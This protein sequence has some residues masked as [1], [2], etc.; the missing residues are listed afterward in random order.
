M[1]R[2][3]RRVSKDTIKAKADKAVARSAGED[4]V[5]PVA[6][7][8]P[9]IVPAAAI[10]KAATPP[11]RRRGR[12]TKYTAAIGKAICKM[13]GMGLSVRKI[14][15]REAMPSATTIISWSLDPDHPFSVQFARASVVKYH[16]MAEEL[17]D[18]ADDGSNDWMERELKSGAVI[19][20]VNREALERSRLRIDTRWKILAQAL[21]KFADRLNGAARGDEPGADLARAVSQPTGADH[22]EDLA[23]RYATKAAAHLKGA[24]GHLNG[25][26]S[27]H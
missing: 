12:P 1:A 17:L 14:G 10:K 7:I 6:P 19:T 16:I 13:L 5:E 11:R 20:V 25:S 26:G 27:K 15:K 3:P 2:R 4:I 22:L 24:N 8:D 21:P 23:K 9:P 18:I